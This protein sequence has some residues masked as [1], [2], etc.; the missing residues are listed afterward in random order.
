MIE[1]G[2]DSF[3]F[4]FTYIYNLGFDELFRE[5]RDLNAKLNL[6]KG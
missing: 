2:V 3:P 5:F 1:N 6:N 4:K